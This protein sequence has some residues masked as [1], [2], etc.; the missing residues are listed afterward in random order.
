MME[1]VSTLK[2][3]DL[4]C[5]SDSTTTHTQN[6]TYLGNGTAIDNIAVFLYETMYKS[7]HWGFSGK[8]QYTADIHGAIQGGAIERILFVCDSHLQMNIHI[9]Q[10]LMHLHR[11]VQMRI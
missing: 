4:K 1:F 3:A 8:V 2:E 10:F 11:E 6:R 7:S 5:S 9:V